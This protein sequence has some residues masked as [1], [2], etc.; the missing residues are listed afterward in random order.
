MNALR[1][2]FKIGENV[3]GYTAGIEQRLLDMGCLVD[4]KYVEGATHI[5]LIAHGFWAE[6]GKPVWHEYRVKMDDID[7]TLAAIKYGGRLKKI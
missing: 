2:S 3:L 6:T 7:A 4:D 1:T 5:I